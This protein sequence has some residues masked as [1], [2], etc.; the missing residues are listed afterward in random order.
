MT[1]V[2]RPTPRPQPKRAYLPSKPAAVVD[3]SLLV[4][5]K[6]NL[7]LFTEYS[8]Q[9]YVSK[10]HRFATISKR[11]TPVFKKTAIP[12]RQET[13]H[14]T[15]KQYV[16][17]A[18]TAA[19][20]SLLVQRKPNI[21]RLFETESRA[22]SKPAYLPTVEP[23]PSSLVF[24]KIDPERLVFGEIEARKEHHYK[25]QK[26]YRLG[27]TVTP[28]PGTGSAVFSKAENIA[29]MLSFRD[30]RLVGLH[31]RAL[32][33]PRLVLSVE[34]EEATPWT[35]QSNSDDSWSAQTN[36]IDVWTVHPD[37]SDTWT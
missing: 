8:H 29:L 36:S 28:A 17:T 4:S 12:A 32:Y 21:Y 18:T 30:G 26:R 11:T 13:R 22:E 35:V 5:K 19:T 23:G 31:P 24:T 25:T 2:F 37:S 16:P 20:A 1:G 10:Q 15:K 7:R 27:S 9:Y 34:T 6:V 33:R 3:A 14:E